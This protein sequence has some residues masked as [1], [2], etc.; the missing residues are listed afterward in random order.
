MGTSQVK[1]LIDQAKGIGITRVTFFGGKP[2]LHK[3]IVELVR[4]AHDKGMLT[5]INTNGWALTRD[6]AKD[7]KRAGLNLCDLSLDD[8]NPEVH[9]RLR[10][11]PGLYQKVIEGAQILKDH[12]IPCQI[13]TYASKRNVTT[14]LEQM[15]ALGKRLGVFAISIVFPMAT[16]CWYD[17]V[18][19]LLS[20]DEKEKVR[21]LG[22]SGF[23]HVE[24]PTSHS[25]CNVFR[26]K[27]LYVSPEGNVC[28]CPFVPY[29]MGSLKEHTLDELWHRFSSEM[30]CD[31]V[32]DCPMN[33]LEYRETLKNRLESLTRRY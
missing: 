32:G 12:G 26:K 27:S 11:L 31:Y 9:D 25:R 21:N 1:S 17:S 13:V 24:L 16:G 4:Y 33:D 15:I 14:G 30:K 22:D 5:R 10:G 3:D 23:V 7:L 8:P 2:L 6:F 29:T 19:E 28:P 18:N 20:E